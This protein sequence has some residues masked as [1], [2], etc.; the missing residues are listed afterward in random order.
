MGISNALLASLVSPPVCQSVARVAGDN[1]LGRDFNRRTRAGV[2]CQLKAAFR[3]LA[4]TEQLYHQGDAYW[5]RSGEKRAA[6]DTDDSDPK[7]KRPR[8]QGW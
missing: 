2:L 5:A 8:T 3:E 7:G 6:G 4:V 1:R